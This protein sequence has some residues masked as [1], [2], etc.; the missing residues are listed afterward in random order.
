MTVAVVGGGVFGCTAASRLSDEGHH[1]VLFEKNGEILRATSWVN[2]ARLHR[3]YHYP[4]SRPTARDC[5]DSA[6]QFE[7]EFPETVVDEATYYCIASEKTKTTPAE[8]IEHCETL[9]LAYERT[10]IDVLN[11]DKVDLPV[12]VEENRSIS[13]ASRN[14]VRIDCTKTTWTFASTRLFR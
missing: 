4:R 9:D 3:G 8:F 14:P 5:R 13:S 1:V 2:Q 12:R 11:D 10:E 7:Q 6:A